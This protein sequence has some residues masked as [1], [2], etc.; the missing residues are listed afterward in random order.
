MVTVAQ[1]REWLDT[2]PDNDPSTNEPIPV[3]LGCEAECCM[4][5]LCSMR[6]EFG[7]RTRVVLSEVDAT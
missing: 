2:V 7:E 1:L 5:E 4:P 6:V 3:I